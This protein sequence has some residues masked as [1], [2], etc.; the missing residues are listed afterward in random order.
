MQPK[1]QK[2][3][4]GCLRYCCKRN[5]H[6]VST[7]KDLIKK[8]TPPQ[9]EDLAP[10][11]C[12]EYYAWK[13]CPSHR[14]QLTYPLSPLDY[15]K[16][17]LPPDY[18]I[19][20]L[21]EDRFKSKF[22]CETKCCVSGTA[23][24]PVKFF[25]SNKFCANTVA[26]GSTW[27]LRH[28]RTRMPVFARR[29]FPCLP[30]KGLHLKDDVSGQ[31]LRKLS[32]MFKKPLS[33]NPNS[34][35]LV[36]AAC[37]TR[38]LRTEEDLSICSDLWNLFGCPADRDSYNIRDRNYLTKCKGRADCEEKCCFVGDF[39]KY[40]RFRDGSNVR[41][42]GGDSG[43]QELLDSR[44]GASGEEEQQATGGAV[45]AEEKEEPQEA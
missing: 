24:H 9:V 33:E 21:Q 11:N 34:V 22:V 25:S 10:Y 26:S 30:G 20:T 27:T 36:D 44:N 16:S 19:C 35:G 31:V 45:E 15:E 37:C 32:D 39:F 29:A 23:A 42:G 1:D 6:P 13:G 7:A 5:E 4:K 41:S 8:L 43:E 2:S 17:T 14:Q 40:N 28:F 38:E 3:E 12:A 18:F